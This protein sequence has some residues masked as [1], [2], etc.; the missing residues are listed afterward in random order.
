MKHHEKLAKIAI[1]CRTLSEDLVNEQKMV[2]G[3]YLGD[4]TMDNVYDPLCDLE[5]DILCS[6][7]F[8]QLV[9][10]ETEHP[11]IRQEAHKLMILEK[12]ERYCLDNQMD[13]GIDVEYLYKRQIELA[14]MIVGLIDFK[15]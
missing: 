14:F 12:H 8:H 11:V 3:K 1:E 4:H 9:L 13:S 5:L 7:E 10:N 15:F 6:L 2:S